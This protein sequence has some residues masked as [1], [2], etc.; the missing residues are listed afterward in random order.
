[1]DLAPDFDEF[2]ASLIAQRTEFLVVGAR[3][4]DL[5]DIDALDPGNSE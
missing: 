1:M 4:K 5:A 3:P 2:I